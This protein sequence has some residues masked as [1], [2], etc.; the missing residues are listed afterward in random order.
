MKNQLF[1]VNINNMS[2]YANTFLKTLRED[3]KKQTVLITGSKTKKHAAFDTP[4]ADTPFT[5][6]PKTDNKEK[7]Y[8]KIAKKTI[9]EAAEDEVPEVPEVPAAPEAA[10]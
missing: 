7:R 8:A 1:L 5:S 3:S 6:K 9:A 4:S 10:A 2:K